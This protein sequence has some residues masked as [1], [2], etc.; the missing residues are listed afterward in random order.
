MANYKFEPLSADIIGAALAVHAGLGPGFAE[1]TYQQAMCVAL[2]NR[3]LV[4][5]TQKAI[6]IHFEGI[7][8]GRY[9]LDLVVGNHIVVELKAVKMLVDVHSAQIRSYLKASGLPIGLL[10]NFNEP[11][12]RV[13]RFVC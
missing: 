5:E 7:E 8:V 6:K 2:S 3:Q 1:T 10:I 9:C 12:L 13:R 4:Y 11:V